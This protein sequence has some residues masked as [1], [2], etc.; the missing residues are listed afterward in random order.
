MSTLRHALDDYLA[1]RQAMGFKLSEARTLLPQFIDF[2]DQQGQTFITTD[3]AVRWATQPRHVQPAQWARRLCCVR[4]FA[5]YHSAIDAR[6]EILPTGLLP[7]RPQ[8]R[9]PYLYSDAEITQLL[10]AAGRLPSATGL[11]AHTYTTVFGLLV[12][13]GMRISEL[14]GLDN[15]DIDLKDGFL[16]IRHS[17]FR[18][19]RCLPLHLTTQKALRGYVEARN[20]VYPIPKSPSFFVSEHGMRLPSCTVRATFVRLSRQIGMRGPSDSHGPR[21]HD[22]RHRFAIQTLLRWYQQDVDVE[23]HLPELSTYL[24]HV[25]VSDTYWYLSAIPELLSLATERLEQAHRRLPS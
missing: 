24:G 20:R 17:K 11:R 21:L 8:R 10:E 5:R 1:L 9:S 15:D 25:K 4:G 19:S 2:L 7:Y 22:F 3:W 18:K 6:T 23:R 14:V 12:V 13:T 16:T